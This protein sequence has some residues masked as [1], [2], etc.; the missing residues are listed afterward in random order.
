MSQ[1]HYRKKQYNNKH[2]YATMHR[3]NEKGGKCHKNTTGKK[4][5]NNKHNCATMH[6]QTESRISGSNS[7]HLKDTK[8]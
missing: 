3:I 8:Q 2:N 5:Y 7:S 1:K 4:Q 6:K